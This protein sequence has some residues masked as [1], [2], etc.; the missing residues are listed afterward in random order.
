M[1]DILVIEDE[2]DMRFILSDSLGAEG[3]RVHT[4]S[5]GREGLKMALTREFDLILLDIML[6]DLN[7][8][9]VCKLIRAQDSK[10]PI[11]MLTAK[12]EEIDKVV[13][14]EVGADD[15]ITKPFGMRELLARIKAAIRRSSQTPVEIVTECVI[16]GMTVDFNKSE[17]TQ[18]RRKKKLTRYENDLLRFLAVHRGSVVSRNRIAEEVWGR[19]ASPSSRTVDNYIARLRSKIEPTPAE[20]QHIL[21]V[22]GE[23]YKLV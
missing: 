23:G 2:K 18:G 6:P 5:E 9:E 8:I 19:E 13:G 16:A 7:G 15:Y 4:A 20:P 21:T 11:L 10:I 14:L 12:G 1:N 3:Y 17:M 22:H